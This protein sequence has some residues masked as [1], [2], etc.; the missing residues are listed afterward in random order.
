MNKMKGVFIMLL[1]QVALVGLVF[2][3]NQVSQYHL[4][5]SPTRSAIFDAGKTS[6]INVQQET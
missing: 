1:L 6:R 3:Q 2:S 4:Y 5:P